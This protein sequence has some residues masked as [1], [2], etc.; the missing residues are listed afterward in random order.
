MRTRGH[1]ARMAVAGALAMA[2]GCSLAACQGGSSPPSSSASKARPGTSPSSPGASAA[3]SASPAW[4]TD[5][6][7]LAAVGDSITRAF[8]ACGP[9]TDCPKSSWATGTDPTV[10]SLASRLLDDPG[11]DSWNLAVSGATMAD[12]PRQMAQA[13][14]RD[15]EL[16]TVLVGANDACRPSVDAMTPVA[17]FRTDFEQALRTLREEAPGSQVYVA[18]IPDLQRLW[19]VG[20]DE[21]DA[22][23]VWDYGICRSML[24]A[25]RDTGEAATARRAQVSERVD[26]YNSVLRE[27]CTEVRRCRWD[28][29]EVH[30]YR[31]TANALSRWDWFHPSREGQSDLAEL[32]YERITDG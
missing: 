26:A 9:L 2:L 17:G 30:D 1:T 24:D 5:P 23:R 7:S 32:A 29:G 25:P 21:P 14:D 31:F 10:A 27:V 11:R 20:R 13:A 6:D 16:V 12:L 15:P 19:Q 4:D 3:P 8:D 18:S 22:R 28:G